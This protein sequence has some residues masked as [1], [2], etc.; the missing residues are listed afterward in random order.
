MIKYTRKK[1]FI[2]RG[3]YYISQG[4][5]KGSFALNIKEHNTDTYKVVFLFP[6]KEVLKLTNDDVSSLFDKQYFTYVQTIP[7]KHYKVCVAEYEVGL[8]S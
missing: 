1:R 3:M 2:N 4:E 5:Y 7:R 8:D 6:D